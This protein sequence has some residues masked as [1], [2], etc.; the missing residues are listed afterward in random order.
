ME[1][2]LNKFI[3]WYVKNALLK[4]INKN[5]LIGIRTKKSTNKINKIILFR[6]VI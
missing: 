1:K 5:K 3:W 2:L 4:I 6:H